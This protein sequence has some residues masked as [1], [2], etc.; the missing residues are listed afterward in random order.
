MS[1]IHDIMALVFSSFRPPVGKE[2]ECEWA[3]VGCVGRYTSTQKPQDPGYSRFI[4]IFTMGY[5]PPKQAKPSR[6]NLQRRPA[7]NEKNLSIFSFLVQTV[8]VCLS[9]AQGGRD[10]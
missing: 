8:V 1:A 5:P 4:H 9:R 2:N 10:R 3:R 6:V 7:H